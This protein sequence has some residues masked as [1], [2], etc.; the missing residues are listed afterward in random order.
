MM[1][2]D[3]PR[4]TILAICYFSGRTVDLY[5]YISK[6]EEIIGRST[7]PVH[8]KHAHTHFYSL[9]SLGFLKP[10]ITKGSYE[11]TNETE[12]LCNKLK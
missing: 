5:Q 6:Y 7:K 12:K 4:E 8:I 2:V 10:S 11:L 3:D 1:L 9:T